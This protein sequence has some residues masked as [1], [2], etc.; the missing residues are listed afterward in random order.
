MLKVLPTCNDRSARSNPVRA[1]GTG[2]RMFSKC[3]ELWHEY[4][5]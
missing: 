5:F 1:K 4:C 2:T 3:Y